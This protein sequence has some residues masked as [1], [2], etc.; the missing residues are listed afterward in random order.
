MPEA[1]AITDSTASSLVLAADDPGAL[2][3]FYGALLHVESQPGLSSSHWR[4]PW[5]AG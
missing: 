3:R 5:P 4:V 2:A 1:T